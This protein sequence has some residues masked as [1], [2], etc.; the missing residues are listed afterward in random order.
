[1]K[2]L[3]TL[4]LLLSSC[5]L[6]S[7]SLIKG[8]VVDQE[9]N[10]GLAFVTILFNESNT[11]IS[12]DI[13]GYFQFNTSPKLSKLTF[14]YIGYQKKV[15]TL[16]EAQANNFKVV[17]KKSSY[18]LREVEIL[19]GENPAHR[20]I[21]R[22]VA[23]RVQNNPERSTEFYYESYNKLTFI[24]PL[25]SSSNTKL[26][27]ITI[28]SIKEEKLDSFPLSKVAFLMESVA[29]RNHFPPDFT[30]EVITE[31]RIAGL[32]TP[33][34]S[35]LGTQLQSFSLYE[36]YVSLYGINY[37]SPISKG[38]ISKY[39]FIL[40]DTLFK[41]EDTSYIIS[42]RPRKNKYFSALQGVLAIST[43]QYAVENF[44]A[45]QHDS[46]SF[47]VKIQQR[48]ELIEGKQWFP[49]QLHIDILFKSDLG[50]T[51]TII[52]KGQSYFRNIALKSKIDRKDISNIVVKTAADIEARDEEY[53]KT[54][55]EVPLSS[56]ELIT[57][58][59]IDSIGEK[60]NLDRMVFLTKGLLNGYV[61]I[62]SFNLTLNKLARFNK[63]ENVR[64]GLGLETNDNIIKNVRIG[65]Y[66][67]YG[68]KDKA[69]KYG[70][71]LKWAPKSN[72]QFQFALEYSNDLI[73]I[74]G[75]QFANK[76]SSFTQTSNVQN[77]INDKFDGIEKYEANVSFRALRDF[78]FTFF[79]NQQLR[80]ITT[81]YSFANKEGVILNSS[82]YF[83]TEAGI[84]FRYSFNEKFGEM[85]GVSLP[86]ITKYP[87]VYFRYS[88]GFD[89]LLEGEFDYNRFDFSVFK[90]SVIKN[91]GT[92]AIQVNAG[93]IDA[94]LPLTTLYAMRGIFDPNVRVA[95]SFS[96]ETMFP[97]EFF[98]DQYVNAFFRH[99]FG[100]L[101]FKSETFKPQFLLVSSF[102]IGSL[103]EQSGHRNIE[104]KSL[105]KGYYESG[106]QLN[107]L[108]RIKYIYDGIYF[109][110]GVGAYY[111]YGAYANPEFKDNIALKLTTTFSM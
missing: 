77:F 51:S 35:L 95:S 10:E 32:K 16:D 54:L 71:H 91:L 66:A 87:V 13:D 88:K 110:F 78:H 74:G 60:E 75:V 65:G 98:A 46:T 103:R 69:W 22:A 26:D 63:Y 41:G 80:N 2:K 109:G 90:S 68:F 1:M 50:T 96:F 84:D 99:D 39:L 4:F 5:A 42:F 45:K 89:N 104:F 55:R 108:Y 34:F 67:G 79:G 102:A 97:N 27:S 14:S 6:F 44:I 59:F 29:E 93:V 101:L 105:E 52:G 15:L 28:N 20:I 62:K 61:P 64:L 81:P 24:M 7:Q 92:T 36:D 76:V 107:N 83:L 33:F 94:S 18:N 11:G 100:S 57:Y 106:I 86:V 47:P 25:D 82:S 56:K 43:N 40:E 48:Y 31:S 58:E 37:L 9:T 23:N 73:G 21:Q 17:L 72:R 8:R 53:W 111:R 12:T 70:S 38:S 3:T 19:P 49:T 30:N 85:L